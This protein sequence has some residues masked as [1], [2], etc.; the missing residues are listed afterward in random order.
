[1]TIVETGAL[2]GG[3]ISCHTVFKDHYLGFD[4]GVYSMMRLFELLK[5]QINLWMN[6]WPKLLR[7]SV[8][9]SIALHATA[10]CA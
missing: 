10:L 2:L 1:M 5:R 8:L 4:D 9:H 6:C 7:F 3:E